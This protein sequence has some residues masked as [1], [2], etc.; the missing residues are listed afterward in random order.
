MHV[1]SLTCASKCTQRSTQR[2]LAQR[3]LA[4]RSVVRACEQANLQCVL[5]G[6]PLLLLRTNGEGTIYSIP[7]CNIVILL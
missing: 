5:V 3:S 1:P 4:Q 6:L 7:C 2:S